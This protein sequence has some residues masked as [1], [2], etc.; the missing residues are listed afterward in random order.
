MTQSYRV[1]YNG[2]PVAES[3]HEMKKIVLLICMCFVIIGLLSFN[4]AYSWFFVAKPVLDNTLVLN[5]GE[6]IAYIKTSIYEQNYDENSNRVYNR[7]AAHIFSKTLSSTT[8][9][10]ASND[11]NPSLNNTVEDTGKG[12]ININFG[13]LNLIDE[14][15]FTSNFDDTTTHFEDDMYFNS[16]KLL[17]HFIEFRVLKDAYDAYLTGFYSYKVDIEGLDASLKTKYQNAQIPVFT[18]QKIIFDNPNNSNSMFSTNE[19]SRIDT[20]YNYTGACTD[21]LLA[22]DYQ[23]QNMF[24]TSD[25]LA[26][27]FTDVTNENQILIP[28]NQNYVADPDLNLDD[29]AFSKS[30]VY[31]LKVNPLCLIMLFSE[32]GPQQAS[33]L[34]FSLSLT[35]SLEASNE[36][37]L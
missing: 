8:G 26:G 7:Q 31:Q 11:V 32:L 5:S 2:Q 28:E 14:V 18:M 25:H 10:F 3:E 16:D 27:E 15:G 30:V 29:T 12:E 23:N 19:L 24:N 4:M 17:G 22:N 9:Q 21:L 33:Q 20:F 1:L 37:F 35:F 6:S 34:K 36:M 13:A